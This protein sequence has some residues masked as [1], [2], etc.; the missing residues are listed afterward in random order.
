MDKQHRA[1]RWAAP[2]AAISRPNRPMSARK[3][4]L[5]A[6]LSD[7]AVMA[8][9]LARQ[10]YDRSIAKKSLEVMHARLSRKEVRASLDA[11]RARLA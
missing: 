1:S 11:L 8:E 10:G 5:E 7:E 2:D 3:A 4:K 9:Y 6:D